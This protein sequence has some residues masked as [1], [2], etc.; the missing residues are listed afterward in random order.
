MIQD[1]LHIFTADF[2]EKIVLHTRSGD[3]EVMAIY[4]DAFIDQALGETV[5]DTRQKRFTARECDVQGLAREDTITHG[6]RRFSV[7]QVEPDGTGFAT[8]QVSD[9]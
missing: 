4:D 3:R 7:I 2:G 1:P 6:C 9:E 5:M 8:I